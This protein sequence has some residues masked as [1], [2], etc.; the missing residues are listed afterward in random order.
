MLFH[1]SNTKN[2]IR[3]SLA[4]SLWLILASVLGAQ[5]RLQESVNGL[6]GWH[7]AGSKPT[8]YRTG[9]EEPREGLPSA[10]LASL[11][12]SDGFGTLMKSISAVNYA[13]KRVRFRGWVKSEDV[14]DWAGLWMRVDT[15]R[16]TMNFD[17][18]E[19]RRITKTTRWQSYDV[20]L[21]VPSDA[22]NISFGILLSGDGEV[23]L[24]NWS[25]DV[26]SADTHTTGGSWLTPNRF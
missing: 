7:L 14:D 21:D 12:H 23:W 25:L 2:L 13:G 11:S 26:V 1:F 5:S 6:A 24:K 19:D 10:Y 18:M 4:L 15:G 22:T 3:A 20:V 9:V 17:N 16:K 8:N